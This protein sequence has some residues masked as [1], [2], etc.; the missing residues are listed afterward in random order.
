MLQT[1]DFQQ[2]SKA[3]IDW[4]QTN[5]R[6]L[7]WRNTQNPYEIWLSEIILQQTRVN[8]GTKYYLRFTSTFPTIKD[9]ADAHEDEIL[10]LWQGLGYYSRARNLHKTAIK[11]TNDFHGQFPDT[12]DKIM[13]LPGIGE[14]T[15]SAIASIA[16][17]LP[18][19]VV[20]GNVY[21]VISRLF[22]IETPIDSGKG[23]KEIAELATLIL[24]KS[25]PANHNQAIMEFGAL[26]CTPTQPACMHCPLSNQCIAFNTDK[27][28]RLPIK[29]KKTKTK[30]RYF[31]YLFIY[32][33]TS[34]YMQKRTEKDVWKNLFEF[35][36]IEAEHL[37]EEKEIINNEF[38]LSLIKESNSIVTL[39]KTAPIKHILSHQTIHAQF[40]SIQVSKLTCESKKLQTVKLS[41]IDQFAVSRL[42]EIFLEK[43]FPI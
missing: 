20:D 16:F 1:P 25:D 29:E 4:Y 33:K 13:S 41:D 37:L 9:L 6:D 10:K 43:N 22:G 34:T 17:G 27:T 14:Y 39:K 28:D 30:L 24:S 21:R 42:T 2:I 8:Q 3:L 26:H 19:A 31:T 35:P 38:T 23:K 40:I 7:P 5:K 18:H 15:A 11:I 36:L 12:Y 32:D